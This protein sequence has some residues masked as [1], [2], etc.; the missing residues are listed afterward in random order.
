MKNTIKEQVKTLIN[1]HQKLEYIHFVL[2][3][4]DNDIIDHTMINQAIEFVEDIREPYFNE[5]KDARKEEEE[6]NKR[7]QEGYMQFLRDN[8]RKANQ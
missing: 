4:C 3:E 6:Q 7:A 2:Q 5:N 1:N 8:N